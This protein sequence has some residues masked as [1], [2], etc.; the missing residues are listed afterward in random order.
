MFA[1]TAV[2]V[3]GRYVFDRPIVATLEL[4]EIIMASMVFLAWGETTARRAHVRIDILHSRFPRGTQAATDFVYDLV[5]LAFFA[6]MA[7]QGV[8]IV[9]ECANANKLVPILNIPFAPFQAM[10][11][12]GA[13]VACLV[14][15]AQL[16]ARI[17]EL[18]SKKGSS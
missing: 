11:P 13:A 14:I 3:I 12:V 15:A 4:S 17:V 8:K 18:R 9:I 1:L 10:V 2:D 5:A 16:V 6:V 7:W